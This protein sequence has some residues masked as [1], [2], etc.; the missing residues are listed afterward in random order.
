MGLP[1]TLEQFL[2]VFRRYNESV[3]PGQWLLLAAGI[4][5]VALAMRGDRRS[6]RIVGALLAGLWLWMGIVYHLLF[7]RAINP[8]A[9]LFGVAFIVQGLLFAWL[10]AWRGRIL[11]EPRRDAAGVAGGALIVYALAIYP[12]LGAALGHAYPASPTFGLP[13][14]TT[15]LTLGLLLWTRPGLPGVTYV[16]PLLWSAVGASAAVRLGMRED[17]GLLAAGVATMIVIGV[18]MLARPARRAA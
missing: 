8:A 4:A 7:F 15:I 5:A 17:L 1:F 11:L 14:P 16:V 18:R 12:L 10:G 6:S 9:V 3:W 2:E 13:C